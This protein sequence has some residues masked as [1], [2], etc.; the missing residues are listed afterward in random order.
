MREAGSSLNSLKSFEIHLQDTSNSSF[1]A[2]ALDNALI[3]LLASCPVLRSLTFSGHL[4]HKL[5]QSM[6]QACPSLSTL[7]STGA[8]QT[9][10][11]YL[12]TML[13]LQPTLLPHITTL[14]F[15]DVTEAFTIPDISGNHK[16]ESLSLSCCS[17]WTDAHWRAIPRNL[18][19]WRCMSIES[20]PPAL[21]DGRKLLT[22]LQNLEMDDLALCMPLSVVAK[23][24]ISAPA[25]LSI[26]TT[27][28]PDHTATL[29]I[30]CAIKPETAVTTAAN[31]FLLHPSLAGPAFN[32]AYL[33]CFCK[34]RG[35]GAALQV[36]INALPRMT[37]VTRCILRNLVPGELRPMLACFPD[38][39][40]LEIRYSPELSGGE[41]QEVSMCTLL[42]VLKL[43]ACDNLSSMAVLSLCH[44]LPS[45]KSVECCGCVLLD[46]TS[47]AECNQLLH[48]HNLHVE[49]SLVTADECDEHAYTDDV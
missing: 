18:K 49:L 33:Y 17:W 32:D 22:C 30:R 40:E 38:I 19:F 9:D 8:D 1:M 5:L 42:T 4:S 46:E 48:R 16:I 41:L 21:P 2:T 20:G 45:L 7:I 12:Q 34:H 3:V 47:M 11:A 31:L 26:T 36:A 39:R 24:A 29:M 6:G 15:E 23:L 28:H 35:G 13:Q 43:R 37:C 44:V 14:T 27:A 10:L 25:L